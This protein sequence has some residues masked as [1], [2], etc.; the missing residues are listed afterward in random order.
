LK[1]SYASIG[2]S[3]GGEGRSEKKGPGEGMPSRELERGRDSPNGLLVTFIR[4]PSHG[5]KVIWVNAEERD[6]KKKVHPER[7]PGSACFYT[8]NYLT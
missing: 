6:F 3:L 1:G 5:R 8:V 7:E 4:Y 2:L